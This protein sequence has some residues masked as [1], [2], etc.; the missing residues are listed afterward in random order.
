MWID[1]WLFKEGI[2]AS[3]MAR[4]MGIDRA[5]LNKIIT[6]KKTAGPKIAKLI[7][8]I[9]NG[10]VPLEEILYG[11]RAQRKLPPKERK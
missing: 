3:E 11:D 4:R 5:Y 1:E 9:T 2:S 10:E 8:E 6:G 7:V